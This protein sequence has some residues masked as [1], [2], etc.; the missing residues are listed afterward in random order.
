MAF[1]PVMKRKVRLDI[2]AIDSHAI[3]NSPLGTMKYKA[4]LSRS[5]MGFFFVPPL[6]IVPSCISPA[7]NGPLIHTKFGRRIDMSLWWLEIRT[8]SHAFWRRRLLVDLELPA[9][10]TFSTRN[11]AALLAQTGTR[12]QLWTRT[13]P[14]LIEPMPLVI[15]GPTIVVTFAP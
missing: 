8:R 12:A 13:A 2:L 7:G 3:I 5:F 10:K 9:A 4:F 11:D 1:F 6:Y 14:T 15:A